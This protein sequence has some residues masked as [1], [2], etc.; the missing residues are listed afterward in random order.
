MLASP[1]GDQLIAVIESCIARDIAEEILESYADPRWDGFMD[2]GADEL[3][4]RSGSDALARTLALWADRTSSVTDLRGRLRGD[5]AILA[6]YG[7]RLEMEAVSKEIGARYPRLRAFL[8][9]S[10]VSGKTRLTL[11]PAEISKGA[12]FATCSTCSGSSPGSAW[13]SAAGTTT[14][15]CSRWAA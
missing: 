9:D 4:V 10:V 5:P 2:D 7:A 13:C 3:V 12:A 6:F 1:R 8:H 11:Q 14:Y 15:T